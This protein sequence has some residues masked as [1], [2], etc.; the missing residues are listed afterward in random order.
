MT[1][2]ADTQLLAPFFVSLSSVAA[3]DSATLL[4]MVARVCRSWR[5]EADVL[6]ANQEEL[7]SPGSSACL[8]ALARWCPHLRR[9][10]LVEC[11]A[12][13]RELLSLTESCPM[14]R[15]ELR[16][17]FTGEPFTHPTERSFRRVARRLE[18]LR[19][20]LETLRPGI[21]LELPRVSLRVDIRGSAARRLEPQLSE[22]RTLGGSRPLCPHPPS[23]RRPGAARREGQVRVRARPPAA[24]PHVRVLRARGR[25][26]ALDGLPLP[27]QADQQVPDAAAARHERQ[28]RHRRLRSAPPH[29]F[30]HVSVDV[31][32]LCVHVALFLGAG[33]SA[34]WCENTV[35]TYN[36]FNTRYVM[37]H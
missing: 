3:E 16:K 25:A 22:R 30:S 37:S 15:L 29:P 28:R 5:H 12:S 36:G 24:P 6:R 35:N 17:P 4:W 14:E 23:S 19:I 32:M 7:L 21:E 33:G 1:D 9:L 27:R 10:T 34:W 8:Q 26:D 2:W 13:D 20:Q 18:G 11:S 31:F